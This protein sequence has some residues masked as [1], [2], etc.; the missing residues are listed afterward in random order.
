MKKLLG[1]VVLGLL[2][3]GN[4]YAKDDL[5][6]K[7]LYCEAGSY[8]MSFEFITNQFVK[9]IEVSP[10]TV[11]NQYF[12]EYK[13]KYKTKIYLPMCAEYEKKGINDFERNTLGFVTLYKKIYKEKFFNIKICG[14]IYDLGLPT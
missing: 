7:K 6:G 4:S 8:H 12:E 3:S 11:N 13:N 14:D 5:T 10:F 9:W 2:L 1:I